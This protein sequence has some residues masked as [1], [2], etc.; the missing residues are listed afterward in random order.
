MKV[1]RSAL[2]SFTLQEMF[3]I[4]ISVGGGVDPRAAV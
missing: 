4:V 2:C 3:L 1:V